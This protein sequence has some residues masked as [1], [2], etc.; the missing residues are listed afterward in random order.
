MRAADVNVL[1]PSTY[2]LRSPFLVLVTQR[3]PFLDPLGKWAYHVITGL[4]RVAKKNL[5]LARNILRNARNISTPKSGAI[6]GQSRILK[7]FLQKLQ[8]KISHDETLRFVTKYDDFFLTDFSEAFFQEI[9]G[10][11]VRDMLIANIQSRHEA[12]K[13]PENHQ[14][15]CFLTRL[16]LD[17]SFQNG[18]IFGCVHDL[19]SCLPKDRNHAKNL[20]GQ[21]LTGRVFTAPRL[22]AAG[23]SSTRVCSNCE[24]IQTHHHL[25]AQCSYYKATRPANP[26]SEPDLSWNT[27]VLFS[28]KLQI[29]NAYIPM[30]MRDR[31]QVKEVVFVDGSCLYLPCKDLRTGASAYYAPGQVKFAHELPGADIS[32][33][34]TEIY[35]LLLV[36]HH[37]RGRI[38]VVTDYS[39][40]IKGLAALKSEQR[41]FFLSHCNN[42]DLWLQ[43]KAAFD[44]FPGNIQ[45]IKMKAHVSMACRSQDPFL[46]ARNIEVDKLARNLATERAGEKFSIF[47]GRLKA[48]I[49]LQAHIVSTLHK[50]ASVVEK[51]VLSGSG[52]SKPN[53]SFYTSIARICTYPPV[54]R[55]IGKQQA[56]RG[57]CLQKMPVF[58]LGPVEEK[59]IQAC[60]NGIVTLNILQELKSHYSTF[61]L[62]TRGIQFSPNFSQ[63]TVTTNGV[64]LK[65][66]SAEA[67]IFIRYFQSTS[68]SFKTTRTSIKVP[69]LLVLLDFC[70]MC[71]CDTS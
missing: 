24:C 21:A 55:C 51:G 52:Y 12:G 25:F 15:D 54:R 33:Q 69:W 62:R 34:R 36:L 38:T 16:L 43:V 20:L 63:V 30:P 57:V 4:R 53:R 23:I 14:V 47:Q 37:F 19:F 42:R 35:A 70:A 64:Q 58:K 68:L 3:D 10:D 31:V 13:I 60:S 40:I 32:S 59:Y 50:R 27:G 48:A 9:L 2:R 7:F 61:D 6:N 67:G 28:P 49:E 41:L 45:C 71:P 66:P 5:D 56:S 26:P 17:E 8:W 39:V 18:Q 11:A 44:V 1:D 29:H 65:F 22:A 46:I